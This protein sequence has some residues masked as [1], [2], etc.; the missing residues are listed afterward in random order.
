MPGETWR[1]FTGVAYSDQNDPGTPVPATRR[2]YYQEP[3]P[4]RAPRETRRHAFQ[5]G[6]R[7]R[8]RAITVGPYVAEYTLEQPI[9][10]AEA[11]EIFLSGI[12]GG[13]TPTTPGGG[14]DTRD[15]T[16]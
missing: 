4:P 3:V 8:V 5:V 13:V 11:L 15:W 9:G 12:T 2:T 16:F 10:A 7:E 14:T 6:T 1:G